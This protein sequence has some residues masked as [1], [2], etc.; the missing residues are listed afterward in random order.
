[1]PSHAKPR[2]RAAVALLVE[3]SNAFSRGL[4]HGIRDW[5]RG[6]GS[7]A[8][9][10]SEQGRGEV[11]P[12]WLKAWRGDGI[13]ARI[14][15]ERIARSVRSCGVPVVNVSAADVA[16]D[17]P[18]VT[19]DSAAIAAIAARHLMERGLRHFG[20]CGDVRFDWSRR[21]GDNFTAELRRSG[22]TCDT[23]PASSR[24]AA[25]WQRERTRLAEWLRRLP[26]PAG[27]MTCYDIR[28][29]QV[30]D[31]CRATGLRVPDDVAV[32]GQHNDE[33]LCELCDPPL[34]SVIP[35]ARHIGFA[36]AELLAALMRGKHPR[37]RTIHVPPVGIATR[38]STDILAVEDVQLAKAMRHIRDHA[39]TQ[40][41]VEEI[42]RAAGMSRSLLERS[43]RAAFGNS[44][45]NHVLEL[46]CRAAELL[47]RDTS[48]GTA[49]IAERTGFGTAE[50]FSAVFRQRRGM[51][52][53]SL[54]RNER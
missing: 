38:Q 47:L 36:A 1:M 7:W 5:I 49:E 21:H 32:I 4:L 45:W 28:G 29:Q 15:N 34:S 40:M 24:D 18:S 46:R 50:H 13:I 37:E 48:L 25:D 51:P 2:S 22:F 10:L 16:P 9:H 3:T 44:V 52:P 31:V 42:A 53:S 35:N 19:S 43:F 33:L 27:V 6:H 39:L 23:F 30:L 26:K 41:G 8:I 20:Y 11:P 54:R 14:E 17:V 12:A